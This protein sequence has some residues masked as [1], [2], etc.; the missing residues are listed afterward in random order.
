MSVTLFIFSSVTLIIFSLYLVK[1]LDRDHEISSGSG[2]S[3]GGGRW[4][5]SILKKLVNE[6]FRFLLCRRSLF[7]PFSPV[8]IFHPS[9]WKT[10]LTRLI[11]IVVFCIYS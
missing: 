11:N 6:N 10:R 1:H 4:A 8:A 7:S 2:G 3:A 5:V 9:L